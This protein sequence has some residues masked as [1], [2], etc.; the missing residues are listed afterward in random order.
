MDD[1]VLSLSLFHSLTLPSVTND[2]HEADAG[3]PVAR[4]AS[5]TSGFILEL[6]PTGYIYQ[7]QTHSEEKDGA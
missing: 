7:S 3:Q 5:S 6:K 1:V 4:Q 2:D